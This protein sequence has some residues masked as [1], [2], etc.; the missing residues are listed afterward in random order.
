MRPRYGQRMVFPPTADDLCDSAQRLARSSIE[1]HVYGKHHLVA[2][3]AG[4]SLEHLAKACL[5]RR[6]PA[7]IGELRGEDS[8]RSLL[9]LL[10]ITS[11]ST[12]SP[13]RTVG[14]RGA[15]QRARLLITSSARWEHL[16]ALADM[17]DGT[18]HA[19][20]NNEVEEQ[21]VVAFVQHADALL[22]DLGRDRGEFWGRQLDVANTLLAHA[23][24]RVA[25][26]VQ[27]KLAAA[28][29]N[30]AAFDTN[31]LQAIRQWA[32]VQ[33]LSREQAHAECPACSSQGVATGF[34]DVAVSDR[35]R[36]PSGKFVRPILGVWFS[37]YS[38]A[39]SICGLRLDSSAEIAAAGME[40]TW[41]E[42][43]EHVDDYPPPY[44]EHEDYEHW[45]EEHQE[46]AVE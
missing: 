6:S 15:L 33:V 26:R 45:R 46:N 12:P 32:G 23:T 40:E 42:G 2:L 41:D 31:L 13:L 10:G 5:T 43:P 29:V 4:T 30:F 18:V 19:A 34:R 3:Y 44:D 21:L 11:S 20:A 36:E 17:R 24:D 8:F 22:A 27:V 9:L 25:H 38:F 28:R 7:L 39:C 1:A 14:L 16:M 35:E 37:A